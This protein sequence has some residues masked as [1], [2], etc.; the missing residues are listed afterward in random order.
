M[1]SLET[2]LVK[3]S[4]LPWEYKADAASPTKRVRFSEHH[5]SSPKAYLTVTMRYY[6][7]LAAAV[8]SVVALPAGPNLG[9]CAGN[10]TKVTGTLSVLENLGP[11]A[12]TF[13]S[14]FLKVPAC[15]AS[16]GS[17]L[18]C[19]TQAIRSANLGAPPGTALG[20]PEG[21]MCT[22][23]V[24]CLNNY[25]SASGVCQ[26][27]DLCR[28]QGLDEYLYCETP[29]LISTECHSGV[30]CTPGGDTPLMCRSLD[31]CTPWKLHDAC[32]T[33]N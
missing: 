24:E 9:A 19:N 10:C 33:F 8:V 15:P 2:P 18:T 21:V 6:L 13:Y 14:S 11:P 20:R 27:A 29:S 28:P 5:F 26:T 23:N 32:L 16:P 31:Y 30:C 3:T 22:S 7:L 17:S 4:T 12:T 1:H 25:C